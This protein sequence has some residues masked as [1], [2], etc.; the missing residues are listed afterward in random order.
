MD[1]NKTYYKLPSTD[2][3]HQ[4][5]AVIWRPSKE[6]KIQGILQISH[7]MIEF[8]ERYE[9]FARY[10]T[11]RGYVV[12][13]HDHLGHGKS[14]ND[15]DEWGYFV[16]SNA[17]QTVVDDVHVMTKMLKKEF[18]DIKFFLLGHSMGSFIA[19]RYLMTYGNELDGAI[20]MGTGSQPSLKLSAGKL[21]V[22]MLKRRYGDKH[23]SKL[24]ERLMFG[25]YNNRFSKNREGK[26]WLTK[27]EKI[28]NWYCNEPGCTF[29]FTLNG[30]QM[31]LETLT[32]IQKQSNINR[33]PKS[34]PILV[35]A[36]KDDPVGNYS[37]GVVKVFNT[38]KKVGIQDVSLKLY[39]NDRHEILN[40]LDREQVYEDIHNW[41]NQHIE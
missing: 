2:G 23:R 36:G 30:Y 12:A 22:R 18:P 6:V 35:T 17:S 38:F 21:V 4:L 19:R 11:R 25:T 31:I 32:Y 14:V 29:K 34:L 24:A 28:C 20:I 9:E 13:G 15:K 8:I 37:K 39:D 33:I 1:F 41:L 7:G 27:D 10:L 5:H 26:E 40:E 3:I 16:E